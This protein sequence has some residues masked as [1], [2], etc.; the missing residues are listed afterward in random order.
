MKQYRQHKEG[1]QMPAYKDEKRNTWLSLFYYEDWQGN[2]K[3][4]QKRCSIN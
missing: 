2:K 1:K 4:K 3:K